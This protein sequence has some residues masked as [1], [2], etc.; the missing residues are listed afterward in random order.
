[1]LHGAGL[2]TYI[3]AIFRAN[4]GKY[5]STMEHMGMCSLKDGYMLSFLKEFHQIGC[6]NDGFD[7]EKLTPFPDA[8]QKPTGG[9]PRIAKTFKNDFKPWVV[10]SQGGWKLG[11]I[12]CRDWSRHIMLLVLWLNMNKYPYI[13]YYMYINVSKLSQNTLLHIAYTLH[14]YIS[15]SLIN[16]CNRIG[17]SGSRSWVIDHPNLSLI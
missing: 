16:F 12:W 2:F 8:S 3:W 17:V 9:R 4:V 14:I 7:H 10:L 11:H 13:L 6:E 1:M 15:M 5:S